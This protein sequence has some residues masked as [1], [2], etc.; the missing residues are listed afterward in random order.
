MTYS[1]PKGTVAWFGEFRHYQ[2]ITLPIYFNSE[3][4]KLHMSRMV[5][6]VQVSMKKFNTKR[7]HIWVHA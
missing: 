3:L 2:L 4:I 5:P 7:K 1:Q 6:I